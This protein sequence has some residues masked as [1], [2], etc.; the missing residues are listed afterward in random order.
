MPA[1]VDT[2]DTY[3]PVDVVEMDVQ[4]DKDGRP[5]VGVRVDHVAPEF[6]DMAIAPGLDRTNMYGV[7]TAMD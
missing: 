5:W 2:A 3:C 1:V 6:E 4:F 7:A